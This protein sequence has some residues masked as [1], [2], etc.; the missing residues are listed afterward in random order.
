MLTLAALVQASTV[1]ETFPPA[2]QP[3]SNLYIFLLVRVVYLCS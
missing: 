3:D 1:Y 2:T